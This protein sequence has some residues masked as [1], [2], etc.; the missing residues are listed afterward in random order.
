MNFILTLSMRK[1]SKLS[2]VTKMSAV[3]CIITTIVIW[4][5]IL[6][7]LKVDYPDLFA[8]KGKMHQITNIFKT[9]TIILSVEFAD[10]YSSHES[11]SNVGH[12]LF[13]EKSFFLMRLF[14]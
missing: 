5:K 12:D 11:S 9:A 13:S 2:I 10:R 7:K 6:F 8:Q 14:C 3:N 1:L 4:R